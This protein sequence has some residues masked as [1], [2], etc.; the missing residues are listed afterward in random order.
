MPTIYQNKFRSDMST[1]EYTDDEDYLQEF[2]TGLETLSTDFQEAVIWAADWTTGT[3]VN[4]L[5]K[6]NID[7]KPKFQRR[8]AWD[9][10]RKSRFIESIILGLPIPQIILAESK[11]KRKPY[12]IIDGKQRLLSIKGFFLKE[13]ENDMEPLKLKGLEILQ[14]LNGKSFSDINEDLEWREITNLIEN[15]TIRTVIIKHWP[16][17][18][19]LYHVFLRINT[20]N[21]QLHPQELRQALHPGKFIDF[22]DEFSSGCKELQE[23]LKISSPDYRMRD[24]ELVVRYFSFKCFG[25][26]YKGNLKVFFDDTVKK[27]NDAW[28]DRQKEIRS[29]AEE[30]R[31]AISFTKTIWENNAFHKYKNGGYDSRFN[32]AIYDIM[33]YY[34]SEKSIREKAISHIEEISKEFVR[35]CTDDN[36]FLNSFETSTKN[37]APTLKRF[38]TWGDSISSICGIPIIKFLNR[39][40]D[41]K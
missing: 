2:E 7:L 8:D 24:N 3:I 29:L 5:E 18:A 15:Q 23:I 25:S 26:T 31:E 11:D 4:Q 12:I 35:L 6:G 10:V 38:N 39:N 41:A 22:V 37:Y 9:E 33:V 32:R 1:R 27:L 14:E 16:N 28:N 13:P 36:E 17:E 19:F 40:W 21:L 20:G 34:F 30:L